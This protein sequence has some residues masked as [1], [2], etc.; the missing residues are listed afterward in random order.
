MMLMKN[1][2]ATAKQIDGIPVTV[3]TDEEGNDWYESQDKFSSTSLKFMFDRQGNIV[4]WS[5]DVS[6][7]AP[8]GLSVGEVSKDSVPVDFF[9][10]DKR[11]VFD[12]KKIIPFVYTREELQQQAEEKKAHLLSLAKDAIAPLQDAVDIGEA[13]EEES[14]L[15]VEWK[16]YRVQV[17]RVDTSTASDI[18]WPEQPK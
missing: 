10:P 1:F 2:T 11:W 3:F 8:D 16:K 13:T 12:G 17:N 6:A 9:E 4:A 5:W 15:L 18:E 7:L 14:A